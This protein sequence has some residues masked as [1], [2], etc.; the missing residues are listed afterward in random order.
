MRRRGCSR[1]SAA[2]EVRHI[3]G[4]NA[5]FSSPPNA[6]PR[7]EEQTE[8]STSA[9]A[10]EE[11]P[12]CFTLPYVAPPS[13]KVATQHAKRLRPVEKAR[14]RY[15]SPACFGSAAWRPV[16]KG[17]D[18]ADERPAKKKAV[19]FRV[20]YEQR[21]LRDNAVSR[22]AA[23]GIFFHHGFKPV[24][25][26]LIPQARH[27]CQRQ[28]AACVRTTPP[29]QRRPPTS[30]WRQERRGRFAGGAHHRRPAAFA[31]KCRSPTP[32]NTQEPS[33]PSS[34][35]EKECQKYCRTRCHEGRQA[36]GT[37][38]DRTACQWSRVEE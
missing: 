23:N 11:S 37:C 26:E 18:A 13:V 29:R 17:S 30:S 9:N 14:Q 38:H 34:Y 27:A 24:R 1:R 25:R 20:R 16:Q 10:I 31:H 36:E 28:P 5:R 7:T 33:L 35:M 32:F 21:L 6:I 2:G 15:A 19:A 22:S 4:G 3:G 12:L 8:N